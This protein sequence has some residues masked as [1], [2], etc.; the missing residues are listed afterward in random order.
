VQ[1]FRV[2]AEVIQLRPEVA[3]SESEI[4]E[5]DIREHMARYIGKFKRPAYVV[6]LATMPRSSTGKVNKQLLREYVAG[7]KANPVLH[8]E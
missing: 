2:S 4:R 7:I 3:V 1:R 5:R 6:F 8:A